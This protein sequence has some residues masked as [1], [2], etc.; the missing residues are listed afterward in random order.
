M[1]NFSWIG[2]EIYPMDW[3]STSLGVSGRTGKLAL[4]CVWSPPPLA[5]CLPNHHVLCQTLLPG[6]F[7]LGTSRLENEK[8]SGNVNQKQM[9]LDC[10]CWIFFPSNE[11][12][13][14]IMKLFLGITLEFWWQY[15]SSLLL[16]FQ[17][18]ISVIPGIKQKGRRT[19]IS[20]APNYK[21]L[22]HC[23]FLC[24]TEM[25]EL[26]FRFLSVT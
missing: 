20:L 1:R 11:K 24:N 7:C 14:T 23:L 19:N 25:L 2:V 5:L 6:Y 17:E 16:H 18:L 10:I 21:P 4:R 9:S 22:F 15:V 8:L 12:A 13:N 26:L 3:W